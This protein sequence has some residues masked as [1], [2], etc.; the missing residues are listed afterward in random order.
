MAKT[1]VDKKKTIFTRKMDVHLSK[2]LVKLYIW[3]I[4]LQV[5]ANWTV[6]KVNQ[7]YLESWEL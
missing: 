1:S 4:A 5:A 6:R 2:K 7:K 3:S